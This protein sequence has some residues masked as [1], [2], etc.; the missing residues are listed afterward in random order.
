MHDDRVP[1][2]LGQRSLW[3]W[4]RSQAERFDVANGG[5]K[6]VEDDMADAIELDGGKS[7]VLS[8]RR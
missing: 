7:E 6:E 1:L 4:Q 2:S 3:L 8:C 5:N